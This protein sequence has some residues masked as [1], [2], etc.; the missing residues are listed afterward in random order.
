MRA[1]GIDPGTRVAGWGV[2]ETAGGRFRHVA[3]GTIALSARASTAARLAA[4]HA[5]V[6]ELLAAWTPAAVAL[7]RNFVAH[8]VQSAFR[9]GEARGAVL[10]AVAAADVPVHEFTPAEV[11]QAAVGH[12]RADKDSMVRGVTAIL[13]LPAP[14]P[15]D[16]ADGLALALCWLQ[17]AP[18]RAALARADAA[19]RGGTTPGIPGRRNAMPGLAGRPRT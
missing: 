17:Q 10:A 8:N 5:G 3:S 9:I 16:A 19:A 12:G 4:L 11:K 6:G 15:A 7:E 14:P 18:L 13:A 1:L 2:V